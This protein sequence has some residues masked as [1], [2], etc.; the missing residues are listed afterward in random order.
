MRRAL[1]IFAL[2]TGLL[3]ATPAISTPFVVPYTRPIS[4]ENMSKELVRQ[5]V[6]HWIVVLAQ[7]IVES[8]W[9]YDSGLFRLTNNFIGMRVPKNRP[10]MR[11]SIFKGYS[12]YAR[13]EDCVHDVLLWQSHNWDGGSRLEYISLMQNIWAESPAYRL[14]L[15]NI[16]RRL[17]RML[18]TYRE[19][20]QNHFNFMLLQA[21][22]HMYLSKQSYHT[23]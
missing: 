2:I 1:C 4:V 3:V 9:Q 17:E 20:N 16:V 14:A 15:L 19:Q 10:S 7:S 13:W 6:A 12:S 5:G 8:G 11:D 21:Y 22:Q 23:E 18:D